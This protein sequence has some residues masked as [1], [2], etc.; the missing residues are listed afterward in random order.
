MDPISRR[1][2]W[3]IIQ[4]TKKGRAIVLTTHSM[5]EADILSD[6]IGIMAKGR[7]RCIGNAIRLKS[8]FGTGFIANVRFGDTNGGHTPARTPVDTSSVHHEAVKKFFK[9]VC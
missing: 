2:V 7:L 1:H 4:N 8:K 3:D 5:E 9:S 6:R